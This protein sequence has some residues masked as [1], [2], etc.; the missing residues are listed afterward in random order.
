LDGKISNLS[1]FFYSFPQYQQSE[2]IYIFSEQK[3]RTPPHLKLLNGQL[4]QYVNYVFLFPIDNL[5]AQVLTV[6]IYRHILFDDIGRHICRSFKKINVTNCLQDLGNQN[7]Q[8]SL[9]LGPLTHL[10]IKY[11]FIDLLLS[12]VT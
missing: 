8:K 5:S 6:D 9:D 12:L 3:H 11:V 2:I 10:S 7:F 4:K 1:F